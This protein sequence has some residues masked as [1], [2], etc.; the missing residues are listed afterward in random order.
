MAKRYLTPVDKEYHNSLSKSSKATL[1]FQWWNIRPNPCKGGTERSIAGGQAGSQEMGRP[2]QGCWSEDSATFELGDDGC[3][4]A[5]G[6]VLI[7]ITLRTGV[8][9]FIRA[10]N[11]LLR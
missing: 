5:R 10:D 7:R 2:S 1:K 6:V 9:I 3:R 4:I 11:F 8:A